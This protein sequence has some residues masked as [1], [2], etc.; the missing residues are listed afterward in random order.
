[1]TIEFSNTIVRGLMTREFDNKDL[2]TVTSIYLL[3]LQQHDYREF[4]SSE[5]RHCSEKWIITA[6]YLP[7]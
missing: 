2:V 6:L 1:M 5:T 4:I 3:W 7:K